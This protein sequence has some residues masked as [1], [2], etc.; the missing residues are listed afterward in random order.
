MTNVNINNSLLCPFNNLIKIGIPDIEIIIGII[1]KE[2]KK[3]TLGKLFSN[4]VE[5]PNNNNI[6]GYIP[7]IEWVNNNLKKIFLYFIII[8]LIFFMNSTLFGHLA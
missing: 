4:D 3:N 2:I 1:N 8:L 5:K 7:I 6:I